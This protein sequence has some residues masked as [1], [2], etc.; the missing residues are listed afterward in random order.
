[1][2]ENPISSTEK[3]NLPEEFPEFWTIGQEIFI[4]DCVN[5]RFQSEYNNHFSGIR[6]LFDL[7]FLEMKSAQLISHNVKEFSHGQS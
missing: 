1:M 3:I 5:V 7:R 6:I 4:N 2:S